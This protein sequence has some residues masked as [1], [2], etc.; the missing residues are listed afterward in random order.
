MTQALTS[1]CYKDQT[2]RSVRSS[3]TGRVWSIKFFSGR[4]L[5]LIGLGQGHIRSLTLS[6]SGPTSAAQARS[7]RGKGASDPGPEPA[8]GRCSSLYCALHVLTGLGLIESGQAGTSVRSSNHIPNHFQFETLSEWD[9]L[10]MIFGLSLS[11]LV[12]SLTSVHHT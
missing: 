5:D 6:A 12:L 10:Q 3:M 9:R 4:L 1:D 7:Y 8:S 2:Q 11:Y